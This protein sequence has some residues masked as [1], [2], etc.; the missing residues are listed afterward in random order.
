MRLAARRWV[1]ACVLLVVAMA[2]T[3]GVRGQETKAA[4][5]AASREKEHRPAGPGP[6]WYTVGNLSVP[7]LARAW[8]SPFADVMSKVHRFQALLP[9]AQLGAS[10]RDEMATLS[11]RLSKHIDAKEFEE[12]GRIL[13]RLLAIMGHR[14]EVPDSDRGADL[15]SERDELIRKARAEQVDGI[16][17]YIGWGVVETKPDQWDW[18]RYQENARE[19]HKAGLKYIPSVWVHNLPP[20]VRHGRDYRFATCLEH[21]TPSEYLSIFSPRTVAAYDRVF[22]QL[23]SALGPQI[24]ALR[25]G[26][27]CDFGETHYPAD[28]AVEYFPV[29]HAHVGWWVGEPEARRHLAGWVEKKYGTLEHLNAAWGT[30][31]TAFA[32]DYPRDPTSARRWL[33]FVEWYHEALIER[34]GILFDVAR[35][36]FPDTPI[37]VNLGW[38]FEKVALGQDL[39]GLVQML[40]ARGIIVRTPTGP[41]VPHLYTRRV[42]T[43][44]RF[45]RVSGLST[46]P[47][48]GSAP[49]GEIAGALFKDLTTGAGWHFDY[50]QNMQRGRDLFRQARTLP[51]HDYP[52]IDAAI[53][54]ST[55]AHRL[56][57]WDNWHE[58][59]QGGYPEG[60][61]AWLEGL[62]DVLDFDVVDERLI[63]EGALD[64]YRSLIWPFGMRVESRTIDRI[65]GWV[66]RGGTL[67]VRDLAA[68]R[69]IEG[70]RVTI[71]SGRGRVLNG[72]GKLETLAERVRAR[73]G[74]M[75]RLPPLDTRPDGVLVS[76]FDDGVLLFNRKA[77]AIT[78]ELKWPAGNWDVRDPGLPASVTIAPLGIRWLG[79]R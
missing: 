55:A 5:P 78:V 12:A 51:R 33:D 46:E 21:A 52:R 11:R 34:L 71:P 24:D 28:A 9:K 35:K 3:A 53:F 38:P 25:I 60:M 37:C 26:S 59:F 32:F 27:P 65:R 62:R 17:D 4:R 63:D 64:G 79:H 61:P 13:N 57:N 14:G 22:A 6:A 73:D 72:G 29:S 50:P 67:M 75:T 39:S 66:E 58:G 7:L 76:L 20:W 36:H 69:T 44:A 68:V 19:I 8:G 18:R 15:A 40:A 56:D 1:G 54:F 16:E 70:G 10:E 41:M 43:A 31:L 47:A 45:Y 49:L 48:D 42:S 23:R 77:E 30:Q 74:G 2:G